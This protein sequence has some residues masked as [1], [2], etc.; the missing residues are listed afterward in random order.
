M[1]VIVSGK[2][3]CEIKIIEGVKSTVDIIICHLRIPSIIPE[4][5][6]S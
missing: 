6:D 2:H 5:L 1:K 3:S 4:A